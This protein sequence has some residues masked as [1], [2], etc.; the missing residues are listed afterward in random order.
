M[1]KPE[2]TSWGGTAAVR[3]EGASR[4]GKNA[5]TVDCPI[6]SL[7]FAQRRC[8]DQ[9]IFSVVSTDTCP[10]AINVRKL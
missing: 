8:R 3:A 7:E 10:N 6:R 1:V 5:S 4:G 2:Q 9:N